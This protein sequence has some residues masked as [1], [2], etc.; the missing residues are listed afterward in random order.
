M[1]WAALG[2]LDEKGKTLNWRTLL[3]LVLCF[4]FPALARAHVGSPDVF[5][6]GLVG[7]YNAR[8]TI[9]MPAVVP[10]RAEI[11]VRTEIGEP[12][13]VAF[14]PLYSRTSITNAPPADLGRLVAGETNLYSGELWLM[15]VGAYSIEIK[16]HGAKGEGTVQI[17]ISSVALSQ[18]PLPPFLGRALVALGVL[19]FALGVG[20]IAAAARE[21]VLEP[22]VSIGK[23]ERSKGFRA[24]LVATVVFV[25]LLIGG[26]KWWDADEAKFRTGLRGGAWPDLTAGV[27]IEN[28]QRILRL[29]LGEK[30]F[31]SMQSI[32]LIPDHGKLLHL[33]L[34]REGSRDAFAHLHPQRKGG[35]TF[36]VVLPPLPQGRYMILCDLTLE[37]SALSSTATNSVEIPPIPDQETGS[38]TLE[39]DRDDSWSAYAGV[40]VPNTSNPTNLVYTL[41]EG[42]EVRWKPHLP[43]RAR[44]DAG[45]RFDV[46]DA[47]GRTVDLGLYMGMLSHAAVLRSDGAIFAHL[48]PSGNFSMAAQSFFENK[49]QRESAKS[50]ETMRMDHSKMGHVM[51]HA[52]AGTGISSISLPYEFP[53]AGEYR[54][55]IQF[56]IG[57]Q[58]LT[59]VFDASV[60]AP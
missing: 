32:P 28:S 21:S 35:K 10:G 42:F 54:I 4:A 1:D 37:G 46:R 24:A 6:D 13:D 41:P 9:R 59:S 43:I 38:L 3:L 18:L 60:S 22:G 20:I 47:E 14:L 58:V 12:L 33:F 23:N 2:R 55:W 29:T 30:D 19:L 16:I 31:P 17:P 52:Q 53:T 27:R 5:F 49:M 8:I 45:L 40:P 50:T 39:P 25:L 11:S 48:H 34:I 51:N 44:S 57:S 15:T 56:K 26:K 7:P 36:D